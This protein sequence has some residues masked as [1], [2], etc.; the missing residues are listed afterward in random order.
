MPMGGNLPH[1]LRRAV[2]AAGGADE[3]GLPVGLWP[4]GQAWRATAVTAGS[5]QPV[6]PR[7]QEYGTA[8]HCA[9]RSIGPELS[10]RAP[11]SRLFV[12]WSAADAARWR[13]SLRR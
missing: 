10:S 1:P 11:T 13:R 8:S 9:G 5:P 3:N 7:T 2:L 4:A 12:I 6:A